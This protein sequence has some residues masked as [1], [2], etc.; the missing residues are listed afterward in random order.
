MQISVLKYSLENNLRDLI[1]NCGLPMC[2][3]ECVIKDVY[4]EVHMLA[5]EELE[6]DLTNIG[7]G[8]EDGERG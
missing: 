3:I 6:I 8:K 1:N 5:K 7:A 2:V 4:N